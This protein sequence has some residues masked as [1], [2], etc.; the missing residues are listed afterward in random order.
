MLPL[1]VLLVLSAV[2]YYV[3]KEHPQKPDGHIS[4]NKGER[5]SMNTLYD[6]TYVDKANRMLEKRNAAMY[7][8]SLRP[9]DSG[10]ISRNYKLNNE[11]ANNTHV[12][13]RLAGVD[14]PLQDFTHN[15]MTPFYG[16]KVKQNMRDDAFSGYLETYT[17]ASE[18]QK[19]KE[20]VKSMGDI[21]ENMGNVYGTFGAYQITAERMEAGRN[22]NN[23]L[24]FD[25]VRVGPGLNQGYGDAPTG[26]FQQTDMREYV[27]PKTVDDLRVATKPKETFEGRMVDG[28]KTT[29]RAESVPVSKNRVDTFYE[30]CPDRWFK[31]TGAVIKETI[32]PEYEIRCTNRESTSEAHI[33]PA[34]AN[35]EGVQ[36]GEYRPSARQDLGEVG[37]RNAALQNIKAGTNDDYGKTSVM[38]Y[39]NQRDVTRC[40]T[41]SG[42]LTTAIK[43]I[44][45]PFQDIARTNTK[46]YLI[47]S[48][49]SGNMN[50]QIPAKGTVHDPND[51][52]RTTVKETLLHEAIAGNLKG[53]NKLTVHDPNDVARTTVKETLLT[54]TV[55]GNFKGSNKLTVYDPNDVAR[56][57]IKETLIHDPHDGFLKG[58][59]RVAVYDP[60]E[61]ARVT[62]RQTLDQVDP[63]LNLRGYAKNYVYDP[64]QKAKTTMKE[65]LED[66]VR[67]GNLDA[68]VRDGLGG[69]TTN[70][71]DAKLTHKQFLVDH[72]YQGQVYRGAGDGYQ[73]GEFEPKNTQKQFLSDHDYYGI[74]GNGGEQRPRTLEDIK[75][76]QTNDIKE[77]LLEGRAPTASGAKQSVDKSSIQYE[78]RR[79]QILDQQREMGNVQ[80]VLNEIPNKEFLPS[81]TAEKPS[82]IEQNRLDISILK[83]FKENPYTQSLHSA[84]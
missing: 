77:M 31:T 39:S 59:Q 36:R 41:Y 27:R 18:F 83:P 15:N 9:S 5:P 50:P 19:P 52:A 67:D 28:Q 20:E 84:A 37:V 65:T 34:Y 56:T 6:S 21:S 68:L 11:S 73:V 61:V 78:A 22:F 43:A 72:E 51:I 76:A 29:M 33:L 17:G 53:S 26:G 82:Y 46:E 44:I 23:T 62:G 81:C 54:E 13:S 70:E 25:Q 8:D 63:N 71:Y 55:A 16:S 14:I 74:S 35:K 38:V 7:Q 2:G 75:N 4:I 32:R 64:D 60:D 3:S 58:P 10:V 12:T 48:A 45:A 30:N 1:Y 80:R 42:N 57:T 49:R 40:N 66:K 47:H 24:P 69:Y 79:Q